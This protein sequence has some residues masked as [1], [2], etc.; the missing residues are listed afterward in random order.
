MFYTINYLYKLFSNQF[1]IQSGRTALCF[2]AFNAHIDIIESLVNCGANV[3]IFLE[4][5]SGMNTIRH[6]SNRSNLIGDEVN[7]MIKKLIFRKSSFNGVNYD[8]WNCD[9]KS[10]LNCKIDELKD[11]ITISRA[12]C[13]TTL[14]QDH[15]VYVNVDSTLELIQ[16][17]LH[18]EI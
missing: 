13:I 6:V 2:A 17:L 3:D 5:S 15:F 9:Y 12:L 8:G 7:M 14:L 10:F 4:A 1:Y 18:E 11:V 16:Q